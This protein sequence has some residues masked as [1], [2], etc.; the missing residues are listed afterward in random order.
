MRALLIV[1]LFAALAV[2]LPVVADN[3]T[4]SYRIDYDGNVRYRSYDGPRGP[5]ILRHRA[6][7]YRLSNPGGAPISEDDMIV[8]YEDGVEVD[9]FP[10][11]TTKVKVE[12]QVA[13]EDLTMVLASTSA[14]AWRSTTRSARRSRP[15]AS[16]WTSSA[17]AWTPA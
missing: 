13:K 5:G 6:V 11:P 1:A 16:S 4:P 14:L 15:R 12:V 8:L 17:T 2:A 9:R 3:K 7:H 10:V